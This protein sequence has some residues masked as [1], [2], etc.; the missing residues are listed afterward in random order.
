MLRSKNKYKRTNSKQSPNKT[1]NTEH[2]QSQNTS[3]DYDNTNNN[4]TYHTCNTKTT[5]KIH[6]KIPEFPINNMQYIN[7]WLETCI[8][9]CKFNNI[10]DEKNISK[11]IINNLPPSILN[12]INDKLYK[13]S[14]S[15]KP[16]TDLSE[17][18]NKFYPY[19]L[20][21]ILEEC[22]KETSLGDRRPSEYLEEL[23][24]KL[25]DENGNP[26][27]NLINFFFQR[28]LPTNIKNIIASNKNLNMEERGTLADQIYNN[29]QNTINNI[30][31]SEKKLEND[32]ET[33]DFLLNK[34]EHLNKEIKLLKEINQ[35][36][37]ELNKKTIS[38]EI[39]N[40]LHTKEEITLLI[41]TLTV[42]TT[43]NLVIMLFAVLHH[44]IITKTR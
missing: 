12:K 19:N 9:L 30:N 32:K 38:K 43:R 2:L 4:S 14:K 15:T 22:Y 3:N 36:S 42:S 26:N 16:L 34:I 20:D 23:K 10:N 25:K 5:N 11:H 24:N 35:T 1:S 7:Q 33:I 31:K 6:F 44:A 39:R 28:I 40:N 41:K 18:L 8:N 17:T 37:P 29:E 27:T 21:R 13:F